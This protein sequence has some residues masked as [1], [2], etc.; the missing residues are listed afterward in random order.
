MPV[1]KL[2]GLVYRHLA[3]SAIIFDYEPY[4]LGFAQRVRSPSTILR[5]VH[6]RVATC[7]DCSL[8]FASVIEAAGGEPL[9]LQFVRPYQAH[10]IVGAWLR[11]PI[12]REVVYLDRTPFKLDR[13]KNIAVIES[14]GV[15]VNQPRSFREART[16]AKAFFR[17]PSWSL[18]FALDV[19][20]ARRRG[21]MPWGFAA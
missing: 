19:G 16:A 12:N 13:P 1:N 17:D 4:S 20:E 14:T 6:P 18:R 3:E 2:A 9:V 10:A 21:I 5:K 8:L 15:T 11:P 7:L